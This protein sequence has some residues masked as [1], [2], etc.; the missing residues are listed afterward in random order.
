ML[1]CVIIPAVICP[2]FVA[3]QT[4]QNGVA[5]ADYA[6]GFTIANFALQNKLCAP[7]GSIFFIM[8][9]ISNNATTHCKM[10]HK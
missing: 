1:Q 9:C 5:S 4:G 3:T 8:T 6:A 7:P 2:D 10:D